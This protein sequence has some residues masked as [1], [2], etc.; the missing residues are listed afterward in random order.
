MSDRRRRHYSRGRPRY[1]E[2]EERYYESRARKTL[3]FFQKIVLIA[4]I[5][6][7]VIVVITM[8]ANFALL[9]TGKMPMTQ[10]TVAAITTY[11]G[12]TSGIASVAYAA[13]QGVRSWSLN[14]YNDVNKTNTVEGSEDDG[15]GSPP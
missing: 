14:K 2:S 11:G 5:F 15:L 10:E 7:A 12:I 3:E 9:W 1:Y 6:S 8:A 13:L 4:F